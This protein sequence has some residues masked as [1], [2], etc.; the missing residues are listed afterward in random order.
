M[1]GKHSTHSPDLLSRIRLLVPREKRQEKRQNY[2]QSLT[3]DELTHLS[4]W[5]GVKVQFPC[6]VLPFSL[7]RCDCIALMMQWQAAGLC[8]L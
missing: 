7:A 2:T 3:Q 1:L 8:Q 4:I 6:S 5:H